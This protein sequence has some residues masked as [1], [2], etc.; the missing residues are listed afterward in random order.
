MEKDIERQEF[1]RLLLKMGKSLI[2]CGA[3]TYR[4]EDTLKRMAYARDVEEANIFVIPSNI[5]ITLRYKDGY[6]LTQTRRI[7]RANKNNFLKLE[8]LNGLSR[9]YC[10]SPMSNEKLEQHIDKIKDM[11]PSTGLS[12]IGNILAAAMFALFFGGSI[13]DAVF[14]GLLGFLIW[15][16]GKYVNP[17]CMN[18][19]VYTFIAAFVSG[20]AICI[21][22]RLIPVLHMDKIMIGDIMLL[23][24]GVMATNGIR[25]ILLRDAL[26]GI[27]RLIEALLLAGALALGLI[28]AL[29]ATG[30]I[31]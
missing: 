7:F 20:M 10:S 23:I 3:E 12:I 11:E 31:Q 28:I 4:V 9:E 24:P 15:I 18:D 13:A 5:I 21:V 22:A 19:T 26:S 14:A 8:E 29:A 30:G 2:K 16:M 1:T 27:I 25:D 17:I 6:I